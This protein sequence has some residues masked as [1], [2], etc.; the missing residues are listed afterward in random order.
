M[1]QAVAVGEPDERLGER[2][3]AFVVV[4]PGSAIDVET[5]RTGSPT[6]RRPVQGPRTSGDRRRA[7]PPTGGQGRPGRARRAR[8]A[9][10]AITRRRAV[11]ADDLPGSGFDRGRDDRV[12]P[13][14]RPMPPAIEAGRVTTY[15]ELDDRRRVAWPTSWRPPGSRP[16]DGLAVMLPTRPSS[17]SAWPPRPSSGSSCLTLNWHLRT[18]EVAWILDDSGA[19]ALVS[20]RA[21][22]P[23]SRRSRRDG[24]AGAVGR[25]R[26][27]GRDRAG[28]GAPVPLPLPLPGAVVGPLH[29][30]HVG[31]SQGCGARGHG[32]PR[33]HRHGPGRP[34]RLWGYGP[35]DVHLV[36]GP[37]Y[38]A[39]PAG[40][41]NT[42]LYVGGTVVLMP[43]VG[44][45]PS[46]CG[47]ST[48][49]RVTTTFLTPAHFIRLLE[50]PDDDRARYDLSSLRH[51]IHAGAPC[52]VAVK[53]RIIAALPDAEVWELYGMS[54][55]GA[56]RVSRREWLERPGDGR[57]RPGRGS[58]C[59]S[60]TPGRQAAGRRPARK[61][62]STC[63]PPTAA[64]STTT[65]RQKTADTW[66]DDA[67]T[68]GDVGRLD[69]DGY[70]YLTDRLSD[71]IIRGGVNIY[72]R[73]VEEV[74]HDAPGGG[75]LR[76]VRRPR[77]ARRR[78]AGGRGR[79]AHSRHRRPSSPAWCR[80]APR[81]LHLP[82]AHRA[83]R[84]A[85]PRPQRQGAQAA[86]RDAAWAGVGPPDLTMGAD[87]RSDDL[88]V[89]RPP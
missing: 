18:D 41:A 58:R 24:R 20:D 27:R 70:L 44:C 38:H 29:V 60:S 87:S 35:D 15:A 39:G 21:S 36:A 33:G 9:E 56:T 34:R 69:D 17:W 42:T 46:S 13:P 89:R 52:P 25:R 23:R 59:A 2:V 50:V 64:S 12:G 48:A 88:P 84:H 79:G 72:P 3:C 8:A 57:A 82:G 14:G 74:L 86:L 43:R 68:V 6:G 31:A 71:L 80:D 55:G 53:R 51:V 10:S 32:R 47:W 1:R 37:L 4:T 81:P 83:G 66:L 40:Y 67:F 28:R 61:G 5:C 62:S 76:G 11:C 49:H 65:T 45:P 73:A 19:A 22:P 7:P 26:L 16:A 77:R 30:G 75:R 78:G 54:E 63:A 85:A